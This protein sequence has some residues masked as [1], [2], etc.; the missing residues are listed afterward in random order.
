MELDSYFLFLQEQ[1][2]DIII[3]SLALALLACSWTMTGV[4]NVGSRGIFDRCF[5]NT[6]ASPIVNIGVDGWGESN[7]M[8]GVY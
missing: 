1:I 4:F 3:R 6:N 7:I 2:K 5:S 8:A